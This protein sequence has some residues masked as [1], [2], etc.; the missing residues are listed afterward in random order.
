MKIVVASGKG[1]T[2]KSTVT[3]N[4]AYSLSLTRDVAVVDC[5]V[6][7]PN[8]HL[9]FPS[10]ST[11]LPVTATIPEVDRSRCTFCGE[12]G[13]F[14]RYGAISVLSDAVLI[15][16]ELCHSCGGCAAV[17]PQGA[18]R[19]VRRPIGMIRCSRPLPALTL[20]SGFLQ[21]GEVQAPQ[22][23]HMAK[24][25]ADGHP[26]ILYDSSPGIAC[27]VIE[28]MDGSDVCIL[29]TE[30]TP[31]GLHDLRLATEVAER[32]NLPSGVVI[33]RSDGRDE[34]ITEFCHEHGLPVL[35]TIPF[36]REIAAVQNTG[37]LIS[38]D[39]PGWNERFI[40]LFAKVS[41]LA[42]VRA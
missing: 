21:E 40:D 26:L 34:A 25:L 1:G 27:P 10:A 38:R 20:I 6:E 18:I 11:D 12:C 41:E 5:D 36:D 24:M 37:G 22:V 17:C 31:F 35:M 9:F 42:G 28:T 15:F 3:A 14:C 39:L 2:G 30:S 8:L 4:L 13:K 19:E 33:N 32:L 29:V 16:P 23:I 7:E